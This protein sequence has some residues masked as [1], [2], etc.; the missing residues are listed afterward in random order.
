V[1]LLLLLV[2]VLACA[3]PAAAAA[4]SH[5]GTLDRSFSGDGRLTGRFRPGIRSAGPRDVAIGPDG[6][7][8]VAGKAHSFAVA[9]YTRSGRPDRS[10]SFDG[11]RLIGP[12]AI[13]GANAVAIGPSGGLVVAGEVFQGNSERSRRLAVF[14]LTPRGDL[15]F[16]FGDAGRFYGPVG[17]D[18]VHDTAAA[19]ALQADGR[20]VL[21]GA[22]QVAGGSADFGVIRLTRS[23][24][25]DETFSGDGRVAIGFEGIDTPE[26]ADFAERVAVR[27]G[28][29][30][31]VG[32][33][34]PGLSIARLEGE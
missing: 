26:G 24:E 25:L 6:K 15:H 19:V 20:V 11:R 30:V 12:R 4:P 5:P 22:T 16:G 3:L 28:R 18:V 13:G 2:A 21:A 14:R 9:R 17:A 1:R 33:S 10:F 23:G 29:I 7:V 8:V 27:D 34:E 32:I 31:V